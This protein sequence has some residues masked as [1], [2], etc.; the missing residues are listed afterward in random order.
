M[1]DLLEIKVIT[2]REVL[3]E[4]K[5]R[6]LSSKNSNGIFDILPE[7]ANFITIVDNQPIVVHLEK[8]DKTFNF[9]QAIIYQKAN[10]VLVFAEPLS[11]QLSK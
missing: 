7:H 1:N 10:K 8:E 3:L 11:V 5:A 4:G 9:S 2:P 6:A